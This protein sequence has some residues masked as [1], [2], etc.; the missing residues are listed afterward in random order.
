MHQNVQ[1]IPKVDQA[2]ARST[3]TQR[4][5]NINVDCWAS[6]TNWQM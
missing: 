4:T 2:N 6:N 3:T 1:N 5:M